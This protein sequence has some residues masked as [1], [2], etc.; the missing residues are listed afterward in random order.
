MNVMKL[1]LHLLLLAF[2]TSPILAWAQPPTNCFDY[3]KFNCVRSADKRFSVNG[4][5]KSASIRVGQ[6][7]E[8]N[9]IIYR[10]QDYRIS[11][12]SDGKIL[13]EAMAIRVLE[14]MRE[15]RDVEETV[16]TLEPILDASGEPTGATRE[17]Q[18]KQKRKVYDEMEKVLWDNTEQDM[19]QE[20]EFSCT[21]TKRIAIEVM[22]PGGAESKRRSDRQFDIGCAGILIEH[23]PT[24]ALGF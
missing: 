12:C 21:A 3:H 1:T 7:T 24:P 9:V 2:L 11:I 8:L 14:K 13:G 22:A 4:Q 10:G 19:A 23:M 17:V 5:S 6:P 18:T 20:L 16:T 15:G